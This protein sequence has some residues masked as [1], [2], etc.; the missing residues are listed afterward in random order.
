[1]MHSC[2]HCN[3]NAPASWT[4][5]SHID[6]NRDSETIETVNLN[7]E[8]EKFWMVV[9]PGKEAA[10]L[11]TKSSVLYKPVSHIFFNAI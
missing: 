9:K 3:I 6:E 8:K 7:L 1:M 2:Y 5:H 11:N 10:R 4:F